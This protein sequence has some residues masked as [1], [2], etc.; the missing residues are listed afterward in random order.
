MTDGSKTS[1]NPFKDDITGRLLLG[2]YRVVRKLAAG[3]MGIVYLARLEGAKGF[4]KPVVVKLVLP[5]LQA[6][7][8]FSGMFAREA[9]I[10]AQLQ[11]PGIVGIIEFAEEADC[12]I[13]VLEYVNGY[14]IGDWKRFLSSKRRMIPTSVAI[15]IAINTLDALHYAHTLKNHAGESIG[16]THRDISPGNIMLDLEGH[17]KLVD[18][19]IA[20][21]SEANEGYRTADHSF[22][23]KL[24]YSAPELFA[25]GKAGPKSDIYALGVTLHEILVGRNEYNHKEHTKVLHAVLNHVPSSI[26]AVR[27][28][29]PAAIDEVIW[30]ALAKKPEHRFESAADFATALREIS[31]VPE[32]RSLST[33]AD[34]IHT[35]FGEE[36]SAFLGMES[37]ASR[38]RAWRFPSI[39][40]KT[41]VNAL[42][43]Q[44]GRESATVVGADVKTRIVSPGG[45]P[46]D[47]V[48]AV[49]GDAPKKRSAK[50][51]WA[52]VPAVLIVAAAAVAIMWMRRPP[53]SD[54]RHF[55][56]VQSELPEGM[57]PV[58][59]TPTT[60]GAEANDTAGTEAKTLPDTGEAP[61]KDETPKVVEKP[62]TPKKRTAKKSG[63]PPDDVT[64]LTS[65]F[66]RRKNE[67]QSCFEANPADTEKI[68]TITVM[69]TVAPSGK[70]E[71]AD[72]SPSAVTGTPLGRCLLRVSK[73]TTFHKRADPI[74][75]KIPVSARRVSK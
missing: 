39:V 53:P 14:S 51:V 15:Q 3:G 30:K 67:I 38:E 49:P 54:N 23:G 36:M 43:P 55:L 25:H 57:T 24:A 74:S 27:D 63:A 11:H 35:D 50:W 34:L 17:I 70:V 19:G 16:V 44:D 42:L 8:E 7:D 10:L 45:M 20:F 37:L 66:K 46:V 1:I 41:P 22:K 26:H 9:N 64:L 13:M 5:I 65:T 33:L 47:V 29:A 69:F 59:P 73:S 40:P 58:V 68:P 21:V 56:L 31:T 75:F 71:R 72:L 60:Q 52:A 18:F 62:E 6:S 32:H 61:K 4:V 48:A 12:N 28:D 2:R